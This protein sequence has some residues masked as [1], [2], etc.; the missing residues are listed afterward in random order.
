[1]AAFVKHVVHWGAQQRPQLSPND[2]C[3]TCGKKPKYVENGFKHPYCSRTCARSGPGPNP[4][5]CTLRGCRATGK[6]GFADFCSETHAKEAVRKGEVQGCDACGI[7]PRS[8]GDLCINCDR[9]G[10]GKTKMRELNMNGSTFKQVRTQFISE[11]DSQ[12]K[13]SVEKVYEVILPRDAQ[14]RHATYSQTLRPAKE[15]RTFHASQCVCNLGVQQPVLCDFKSCGTCCILKSAFR[16]FAFGETANLGRFGAG[17]YTY[18]NP[19][20]ADHFATSCT[21]SPYRVMIACDVVVDNAVEIPMDKSL[22]VPTADA[23]NPLYVIMY[24]K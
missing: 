4:K 19:E 3:E 8:I 23:I 6:P 5:S 1:M 24:S 2:L 17:I 12:V 11:W 22:F 21:S 16:T 9:N 15:L 14:N 10:S 7:Q 13:P 18:R 20:L